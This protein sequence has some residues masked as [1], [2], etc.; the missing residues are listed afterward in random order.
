MRFVSVVAVTAT[1]VT[2]ALTQ[3][4]TARGAP[5]PT[6]FPLSQI[7]RGQ[8]GYGL[9]TMKGVEPERFTF[10]VVDVVKNFLPKQ[11]IIMVKSD[12]PKVQV[13]GFWQGMSGS[14][15]FIDDKIVCA[16]SY[17]FK[18]NKV[19]LGGCT[20]IEYMTRDG[21]GTAVRGQEVIKPAQ[22]P[23]VPSSMDAATKSAFTIIHPTV[24]ST[25]DWR[26]LATDGT[27]AAAMGGG[28]P[29]SNWLTSAPLATPI[30]T[31]SRPA[32][33]PVMTASVPLAV[34]GFSAPAFDELQQLFGG[35][36]I[37]P[38]RAGGTGGGGGEHADGPSAF[39]LGGAISVELIRGD[40]SAAATGTVSYIDGNRVLAFGHPLFQSGEFYAP[41][42]TAVVH[43]VIPSSQ[44]AFVMASPAKEIGALVLDR[45]S[46]IMADTSKRTSMIPLDIFITRGHGKGESKGEFHVELLNNKYYTA[47]LAGNAVGSAVGYY[48]PDHDNVTAKVESMV[49]IKGAG[50]FHFVDYLYAADGAGSVVGS[51]RAIRILQ[52]L[53]M[54][55]F[56]PLEIERLELKVELDF[57]PNY[58]EVKEL[59]LPSATLPPGKRSLVTVVMDT[60]D[61]TEITEDI[62]VDVPANLA[63]AIVQLDIG[64]GDAARLDV[65]PPVDLTTMLV[66]LQ[67]MLPGTV[68]AATISTADEGV[69]VNGHVVHDL[70]NGAIDK[71]H[72]ASRTQTAFTYKP[73]TRTLS[74]AHRV[75][76]GSASTM[77]RIAEH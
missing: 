6:I 70:P 23:N 53:L 69:A 13:T 12:D 55:P 47:Q 17:G 61:G 50:Q 32:D 68:W 5:A 48:L 77:V 58:G 54:N 8:T 20:P 65:A 45:Q 34:A 74:P 60:Y 16:F 1:V 15:L 43:T 3:P 73:M 29:R 18:F 57:A 25:A 19:A 26:R 33:Q 9:T 42:Y 22:R 27:V 67:K 71:L 10:E 36:G 59:R 72:P 37:T 51:A 31:P 62:P 40:M 21:L 11:D 76:T 24:A 39:Q 35:T 64:A 28:A 7:K 49:Q 14:P 46:E 66:I 41:V 38:V 2:A 4:H 52:P 75:I 56:S 30:A 63:G 44:S